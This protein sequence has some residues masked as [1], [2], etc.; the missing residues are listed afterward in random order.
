[1]TPSGASPIVE[2]ALNEN[3]FGS[4]VYQEQLP[5]G[6]PSPENELGYRSPL[7]LRDAA[8]YVNEMTGG[9]EYVP[10]D[11]DINP[12]RI[13][14][15]Y[16]FYIGGT[17][18]FVTR[19]GQAITSASEMIKSGQH[20][21]MSANDLPMIRVAWGEPSK[22]YDINLYRENRTRI[23]QLKDEFD[24][25][26][27][28]KSDRDRYGSIHV[29]TK[30]LERSEKE[31]KELRGELRKARDIQDYVTRKNKEFDLLEEQRLVMMR[32]NKIY[33][34]KGPQED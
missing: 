19:T 18:R 33:N 17:G 24:D 2:S 32:F 22:F 7:W 6:A 23:L 4:Q 29:V 13:W 14:H 34:E 20:M 8:N 15:Y 27:A 5:F 25:P 9:S 16:N 28:R 1:M 26:K 12:D 31:L 10:G 21:K 30:A 11:I 3:F